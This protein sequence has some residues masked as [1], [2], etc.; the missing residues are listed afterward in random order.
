MF[1]NQQLKTLEERHNE[2][3]DA[4][5]ESRYAYLGILQEYQLY[6][7]NPVQEIVYTK[8]NPYQHFLFKRVLHGTNLYTQQDLSK[9]HWDKKRRIKKVWKRGQ[10][11]INAWKQEIC[12]RASNEIFK[13]FHHSELA[14]AILS[15]PDNFTDDEYKN[16]MT[17]KDLGIRYEDVIL[18]FMGKGLLPSNFLLLK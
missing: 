11:E 10:R 14:K 3:N 15:V 13:I 9:M 4:L 12:N 5:K 17:F 8:L 1:T 2:L 7:K 16:S 6:L 18:F